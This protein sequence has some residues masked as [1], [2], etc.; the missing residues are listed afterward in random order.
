M[1]ARAFARRKTLAIK[2]QQ[3]FD[4]M[5]QITSDFFNILVSSE[6]PNGLVNHA[7]DIGKS[8]NDLPAWS[9]RYLKVR[10]I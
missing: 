8:I 7:V 5:Q 4:Q 9:I 1:K 2:Q 10:L 3:A 6:Y